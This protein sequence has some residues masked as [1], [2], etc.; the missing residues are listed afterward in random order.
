MSIKSDQLRACV[1][2]MA[3]PRDFE[4]GDL[5]TWKDPA[6]K[7]ARYPTSC[8]DFAICVR[9]QEPVRGSDNPSSNQFSDLKDAVIGLM[10]EDGA[11][12]EYSVNSQ[13]FKK[14]VE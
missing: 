14:F 12:S 2:L 8:G 9:F 13:R 5:V 1:E 3:T 10:A 6:V 11:Y 4:V 7:N